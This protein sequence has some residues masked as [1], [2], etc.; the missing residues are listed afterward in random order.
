MLTYSTFEG[1][2]WSINQHLSVFAPHQTCSKCGEPLIKSGIS[3]TSR[4]VAA[5]VV[6]GIGIAPK[7]RHRW[8][9]P[10][11]ITA[12]IVLFLAASAAPVADASAVAGIVFGGVTIR[13]AVAVRV[14]A[15]RQL[16]A[17]GS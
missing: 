6:W 8:P 9:D 14:V 5:A 10:W 13:T 2:C 17:P 16:T 7:A 1:I 3:V 15:P 11:R 4:P 12:E